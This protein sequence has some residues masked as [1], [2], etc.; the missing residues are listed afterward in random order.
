MTDYTP[1]ELNKLRIEFGLNKQIPKKYEIVILTVLSHY[2][3]LKNVSIEFRLKYSS[4]VP[5]NTH[6]TFGSI[7]RKP[8]QRNYIVN[9]LEEA[10][11]SMVRPLFKNLTE[12]AQVVVIEH[13]VAHVWQFHS[14]TRIQ[15]AKMLALFLKPAF[16][17]KTERATDV[18]AIPSGP[19]R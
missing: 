15:Q 10:K 19:R 8:D 13:E 7:F 5:Y 4:S 16:L 9:I 12:D 2:P 18:G 17:D 6:P 11:E 3:E 1:H 14:C